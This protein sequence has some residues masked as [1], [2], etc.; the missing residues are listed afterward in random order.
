M[1][2]LIYSERGGALLITLSIM[3]LLSMIGIYLANTAET[4]IDL[5]F[6]RHHYDQ[7]FYVAQAGAKQAFVE[8][9]HDNFWRTG[10][11]NVAFG[12][13][14]YSVA[15]VDSAADS[16][17]IDTVI[18]RG[19][20]SANQ[21]RAQVELWTV[22]EYIYPFQYAMFAEKSIDLDQITCTDSYDSDSGTYAM[23]REDYMGDVGSNGTITTSKDVVIGGNV[24]TSTPG[25]ISLGANNTIHGDTSST[26]DSVS[27]DIVPQSEYDWAEANSIAQSGLSGA[28][29]NYNNGSK[30]LTIGSNGTVILS[31]G[32]YY[33]SEIEAQQNSQIL[34]EMDAE[35][36]IYLAG[37]LILRQGSSM[38][39]GGAPADMLIFSQG[40]TLQF[41]Q[42]N[43]FHGAF[44]GPDAHIQYDQTTQ[45]YGALVGG[46]IKLDKFACFHYDR[47]LGRVAHGQTGRM[48]AI[49]WQ[50]LY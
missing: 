28:N 37:D 40:S 23:T 35:V 30:R 16:A 50:E 11:S 36:M 21:S 34:L 15:L 42:D 46:T 45:V 12:V 1:R 7:A 33:F 27:L 38:N 6:N 19:E 17:L 9:N 13:G 25:G 24:T 18:I 31:S 32:V 2:R 49:A 44:F 14:Q 26:A 4:D 29:Y 43:I 8:L 3:L 47:A 22:P 20:G 39:A 41:D 10:Y 48:L 5:S